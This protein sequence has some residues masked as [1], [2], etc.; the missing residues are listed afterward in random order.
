LIHCS[1]MGIGMKREVTSTLNNARHRE[2]SYYT[3]V[4]TIIVSDNDNKM[5]LIVTPRSDM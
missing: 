5:V 1:E 4:T 3:R 2:I